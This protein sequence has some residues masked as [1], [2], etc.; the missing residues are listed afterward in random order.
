NMASAA[1]QASIRVKVN[2]LK[3][4]IKNIN[5]PDLRVLAEQADPQAAFKTALLQVEAA[6][7]RLERHISEVEAD[8]SAW[9]EYI[10]QLRAAAEKANEAS[11]YQT[12]AEAPDSFLI[13]ISEA[14]NAYDD[15][16]TAKLNLELHTARPTSLAGSVLTG[17]STPA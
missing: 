1:Y 11:I 2:L 16:V 6:I 12:L 8:H 7:R 10:K 17:N 3:A 13:V 5:F 4:V 15:L 14:K 9:L